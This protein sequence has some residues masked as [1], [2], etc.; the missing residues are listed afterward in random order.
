MKKQ[1]STQRKKR[2]KPRRKSEQGFTLFRHPLSTMDPAAVK[3]ELLK[4]ADRK[5]EEFPLLI[6]A[7]LQ[8]FRDKYP[9]HI[10]AVMAGYGLQAGVSD[11]GVSG[12]RLIS[13]LEQHHLELLQSL[14]LTLPFDEWGDLPAAPSDIQKTIDTI[15]DLA[16]AFH[17]RRFK[18]I[19]GTSDLQAR[20]V[21]TLQERLRLHTQMIRNWGYFAEVVQISSELYAPLDEL[22]REALGFGASDLIVVSRHLVDTFEHRCNERFK[23]LKR[24]FREKT[25]PGLV[26]A[27]YEQQPQMK[28]DAEKFLKAIPEGTTREEVGYKLLSHSDISFLSLMN[29]TAAETAQQSGIP[30]EVTKRVLD[31]LSLNPGDLFGQDPERLFMANPV[32]RSPAIEVG[33]EYF[34]PLP[35]SIFSHIHEIMRTLAE[36]AGLKEALEVRRAAYLETKVKALLAQ[37][38][39]T[40]QF[41]QGIKWRV[42]GVEYE[43]DHVAAIDRTVVIVE[44]KSAAL[45]GP[46]L[47]GA[48]DRVRRHIGDLIAD[49]SE[50]SERL[51]KMIWEANAGDGTAA[52]CLAPFDLNFADTERV[53]RISVTLD[54]LSVLASAEG[55]L[56]E[57]GWIPTSL[58]LAPTLNIADFQQV[59][60]ILGSP[61]F[62]LHYFAERGLFQRAVRI[63]ADEMD[64]LGCYLQ[65]GFNLGSLEKQKISLV[66]TGM[67]APIDQYCNS[68]DAGVTLKK[69]KPKLSPYF[70]ALIGAI[71]ER[72]F[73]RWS[74][75][76]TDLLRSASYEE[77]MKIDKL[78]VKLKTEV[79]RHWRNPEHDCS[80]IVSPPESRDTAVVFYAYPPQLASRRKE[81]AED[82]ALTALETSGRKR[83]VMI[84]R[85]IARWD[86][87]YASIVIVNS[88]DSSTDESPANSEA[89]K[90]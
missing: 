62:F 66:L 86:A 55:D 83:C 69:P 33:G 56:K 4:V 27:Y 57:V 37:A 53:V 72:A 24:I 45:T 60:D 14:L 70:S 6:E 29:F 7:I 18:A 2:G 52:A 47:R 15:V 21:L 74:T 65:T 35:Q 78:L 81:I 71:E 11:A 25:T 46:G 88:A 30:L 90:V 13:K 75:V 8:I 63:F 85:N 44:D 43:T 54:D 12:K 77:Q 89:A 73:P 79:E 42:G 58:T 40:A 82:L 38:L 1:K 10:M 3:T 9:P 76:T 61:S 23:R 32:W 84:C 31:A 5:T 36:K 39:P 50:Q 80:L 68:R 34:C 48:P 59:I 20:T 19:E 28:G 64:F 17:S 87:P 67:S 16:D 26:R 51:E 49:P 41:R 22:F